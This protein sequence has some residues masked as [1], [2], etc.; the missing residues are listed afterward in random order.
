ELPIRE[1]FEARRDAEREL[2]PDARERIAEPREV[3]HV[4]VRGGRSRSSTDQKCEAA[5]HGPDGE[6]ARV[7]HRSPLPLMRHADTHI[8]PTTA[9]AGSGGDRG[10]VAAPRGRSPPACMTLLTASPSAID[11][12]PPARIV[13]R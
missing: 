10:P 13:R 2:A 4:R 6:H 5:N 11:S 1:L 8:G 9:R 7:S 12:I 3:H